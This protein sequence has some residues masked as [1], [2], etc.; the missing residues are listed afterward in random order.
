MNQMS[1]TASQVSPPG[2]NT[3]AYYVDWLQELTEL[4]Q[5][6]MISDEDYAFSRAE[7]L[8][9]LLSGPGKPWVKW[10]FVGLP[11][12]LLV[13]GALTFLEQRNEPILYGGMSAALC[14]LAAIGV[15]SRVQ[16]EHLSL[17]GRLDILRTLLERDLISSSEFSEFESRFLEVE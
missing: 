10:L 9:T 16:S 13:G 14:L 12:S 2:V 7:R 6:G 15:H 17:D 8:D 3:G 5:G 4:R 11:L 1:A